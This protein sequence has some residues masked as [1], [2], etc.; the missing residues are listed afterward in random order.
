[1][2]SS[3]K[4]AFRLSWRDTKNG[5]KARGVRYF[6]LWFLFAVVSALLVGSHDEQAVLAAREY[7]WGIF[8]KDRLH[9]LAKFIHHYG[10][11]VFFNLVIGGMFVALGKARGNKYLIRTATTL[12]L[13]GVIAG[14]SVQVIKFT[15]GRPR[16]PL[17]QKG[18]AKAWEFAGPTLSAKH[19]SYPSGHSTC[20]ATAMTVLAF[21]FSRI[22]PL[23]LFIALSAGASRVVHNYHFPTDVL[24]GLAFGMVVGALSSRKITRLRGRLRRRNRV[25]TDR[26]FQ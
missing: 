25:Q 8:T 10:D 7:S 4:N 16:P 23:A 14:V 20:V 26:S 3:I 9:A 24:H 21:A 13:S 1:M 2:A 19:R 5:F 22:I 17:V 11:F 6:L 15:A 18:K 12:L